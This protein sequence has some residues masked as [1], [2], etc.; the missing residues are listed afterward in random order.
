[1]FLGI[2]RH[3]FLDRSQTQIKPNH[4]NNSRNCIEYSLDK[5]FVD[6]P[7]SYTINSIY[8][9]KLR[10]WYCI[11]IMHF[12]T[13]LV[14]HI[15]FIWITKRN[16]SLLA[17]PS[18]GKLFYTMCPFIYGKEPIAKQRATKLMR[19]TSFIWIANNVKRVIHQINSNCPDNPL[20]TSL[21]RS[22]IIER[23]PIQYLLYY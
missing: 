20:T 21:R 10:L 9:I 18:G 7:I 13:H 22:K 17:V 12:E 6:P 11:L 2:I 14:N 4:C 8:K 5:C 16:V 15:Q 1:M 3:P 23:K 19:Q